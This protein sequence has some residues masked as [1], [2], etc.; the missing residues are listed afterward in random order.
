MQIEDEA[1]P[2]CQIL[3]ILIYNLHTG[4]LNA[5]IDGLSMHTLVITIQ[6]WDLRR[7]DVDSVCCNRA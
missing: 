3:Y 6:S 7:L 1:Q 2:P 5:N 4:Q